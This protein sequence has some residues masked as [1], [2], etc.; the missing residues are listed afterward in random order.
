GQGEITR[1][2]ALPL[3]SCMDY[4]L[5]IDFR[6]G[7]YVGQE[8]TIRTHHTGVVRKRILPVILYEG[9]EHLPEK[10]TYDPDRAKDLLLPPLPPP[11]SP[12]GTQHNI[13][14]LGAKG[15]SAGKWL[16][17]VGNVGLALCRLELMVGGQAQGEFCVKWEAEAGGEGGEKATEGGGQGK[18]GEVRVKAF[19]PDW[20]RER[21]AMVGLK[22]RV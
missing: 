15:R 11:Q 3:E 2:S 20:H 6:K 8:L 21:E 9:E 4:M 7:C 22:K 19:V 12:T 18:R 5:G 16:G 10:L 1:E 13:S 17:G 14:R